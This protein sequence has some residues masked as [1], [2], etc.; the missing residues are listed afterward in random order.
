[1]EGKQVSKIMHCCF[2]WIVLQRV[3]WVGWRIITKVINELDELCVLISQ[4]SA[5]V[6]FL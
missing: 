6:Y 3:F 5:G 1:M 4:V 2:C